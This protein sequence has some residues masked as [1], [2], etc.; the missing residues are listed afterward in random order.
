MTKR[1]IDLGR[2]KPLLD[3]ASYGRAGSASITRA[4]LELIDRTVR[5]SPE[6]V[7]KVS[8]G[9]RTLAGVEGHLRYIGRSGRLALESD[10]GERVGGKGI[11]SVLIEDWNL[12]LEAR[13]RRTQQSIRTARRPP[14]LVHN[15]IFSMP[16]GTPPKLV[17][18]AVRKLARDQFG[19]DHRYVLVLHTEEPH[20]HVHLVVKAVGEQGERLNIRKATLREW[21]RDFAANLRELG[22]AANATERAVRGNT[23]SSKPDGIYRTERRG[24]FYSLRHHAQRLPVLSVQC[25]SAEASSRERL[26]CT[27]AAV[28][29]GWRA[30]SRRLWG[31]GDRLLAS[32]IERFIDQ[33]P[34]VKTD[35]E[36][37]AE[38][39]RAAPLPLRSHR[40]ER[41]R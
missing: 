36:A 11:E 2:G 8:G 37:I 13:A 30:L 16:A 29:K 23:R 1:V 6:V 38:R 10:S 17:L 26:L 22:V 18:R 20:P 35:A 24:D 25:D 15:L 7:V 28:V 5:R 33:M 21:R 34:P 14:K 19:S 32:R 12:D 3:I 41:T 31:N 39:S 9:A 40:V 27:R 4:E